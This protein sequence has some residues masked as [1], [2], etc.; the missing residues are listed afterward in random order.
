[1][2]DAV[3]LEHVQ[4]HRGATLVIEDVSLVIA[5][6]SWYGVIG[7]NGAGKT[8]L[9]R[10]LGGRLPISAGTCI[11]DGTD[12]SSR[13]TERAARIGFM[14]LSET[15]P[16]VL[17][18][19]EVLDLVARNDGCWQQALDP[20][21]PALG[22]AN[23]LERNI[24]TLSA[25]MRQRLAIACAFARGQDLVILDEPFN[26]LDPVAGFDL[27]DSLRAMVDKGLTLIT[28]LHDMM[29]LMAVCDAGALIGSGRVAL[30]LAPDDL[31]TWRRDPLRFERELI[32][33]L[34]GRSDR[35]D[36]PRHQGD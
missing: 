33:L 25:G 28:A 2:T 30:E 5:R 27:R 32:S 22:L 24:G 11:L 23:L 6:G 10:A 9:L 17:T 20:L 19:R 18:G 16:D 7:A 8:T 3:R 15:L 36:R 13:R 12:L 14:P 34:R 35:A 4:V 1:M 21:M 29:T 26:S 31:R